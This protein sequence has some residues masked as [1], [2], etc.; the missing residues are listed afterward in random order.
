[1]ATQAELLA[2]IAESQERAAELLDRV[3]A[4][5]RRSA[6]IEVREESFERSMR[7]VQREPR[8]VGFTIMARAVPGLGQQFAVPPAKRVP[9]EFW[10]LEVDEAVVA[11][12]C[13]VE[14]RVRLDGVVACECGR[15]FVFDGDEVRARP[16]V[17]EE[18]EAPTDT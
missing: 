3:D 10:Q 5:E 18:D 14:P 1:M 4:R 8:R 2:Q 17:A 13:G 15:L 11:C 12:P 6:N 9:G 7:T 16:P